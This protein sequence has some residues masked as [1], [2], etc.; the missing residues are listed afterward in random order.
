MKLPPI[1]D[2]FEIVDDPEY[3]I[4]VGDMFLLQDSFKWRVTT[5]SVGKRRDKCYFTKVWITNSRKPRFETKKP[6]PFGY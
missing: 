1:P 4:S 6:Y 2:G 5:S 3:F